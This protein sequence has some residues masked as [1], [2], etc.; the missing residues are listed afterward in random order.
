MFSLLFLGLGNKMLFA[1]GTGLIRRE[2]ACQ[3]YLLGLRCPGNDVIRVENANY[4]RTDP[5]VCDADAFQMHN[6]R[7]FLPEAFKITALR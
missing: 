5:Q 7:C 6:V 1:G 2:L 3:G 4:G